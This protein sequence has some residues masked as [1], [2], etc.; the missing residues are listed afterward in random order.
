LIDWVHQRCKSWGR[1]IRAIHFGHGGWPPRTILDR[2]IREGILGAACVRFVQH[3]PEVLGEEELEIGNAVKRLDEPDREMLFVLYVVGLRAKGAMQAL[4]VTRTVFYD[5]LD[6]VHKRV[7]T[8][9]Y[10]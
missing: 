10:G 9:L 5:R 4:E 2:M 7:S 3:H 8:A 6:Q 1:Q